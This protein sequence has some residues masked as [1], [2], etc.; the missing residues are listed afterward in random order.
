MKKVIIILI[1][2]FTVVSDV[3]AKQNFYEKNSVE[4]TFKYLNIEWWENFGDEILT[5]HIK[6]LYENNN[7]IKNTELKI[8][9]NENLV[10][11]EFSNELPQI[12]FG[13]YI[14]REFRSSVQQFGSMSIASYAQNNFQF[15]LTVSYEVD[16]WGKK[17]LKTKSVQQAVIIAQ[18]AQ[19]AL[20]I[21]LT[22]DF[23]ANYFNLIKTDRLLEIQNEIIKIQ[24]E[25]VSR[26]QDKYKAGLCSIN[27]LLVEEKLLTVMNEEKNNLKEKQEVLINVLKAYLSIGEQDLVKRKHFSDIVLLEHIPEKIN[28]DIIDNR[29]D[30]IQQEANIKR[31]G[32]DVRAAKKEMLPSIIISGQIGLNSYRFADL[33]KTSTQLANAGIMPVFDIFS[34]GK[35]IALLRLRKYQYEEAVNNYQQTIFEA[36]KELNTSM[37]DLKTAKLNYYESQKQLKIQKEIYNNIKYKEKIG[38][39]SESDMLYAAQS[40]LETEKN[41]ISNKIN[42]TIAAISIYKATGGK[43]LCNLSKSEGL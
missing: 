15:P 41:S 11:I 12:G 36:V 24:Q 25:I 1:I 35:K 30:Y 32:Y 33:F 14:G 37:F 5:E 8:K 19:R 4:N 22:S 18:Q 39:A 23:A 26:S 16:I 38:T 29:P 27:E 10:K 43:N 3:Y 34:G 9:E 2:I 42:Y 31:L 40:V 21:S 13:G 28:S 7:D 6:S 20:F 17:R